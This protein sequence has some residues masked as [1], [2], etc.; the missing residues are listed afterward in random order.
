MEGEHLVVS[1]ILSVNGQIIATQA[2]MDSG[3]TGI[4]I[5]DKDFARHHQLPLIHL[6]NPRSFQVIDG[7][8]ISSG[9]ITHTTTVNLLINEHPEELP[10]FVTQL[11]HYPIVFSIPKMD[12]HDINIRFDSCTVTFGSLYCSTHYFLPKSNSCSSSQA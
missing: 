2:Q 10:M 5:I 9:N 7:R 12:L 6:S 4:A 8:P 11:G 3:V 1:C